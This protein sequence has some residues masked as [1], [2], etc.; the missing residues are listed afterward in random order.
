MIE[1]LKEDVWML[2]IAW[3][4]CVNGVI[5][6]RSYSGPQNTDTSRSVSARL[7]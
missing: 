4:V 5:L 6:V 3:K 7:M 2:Y 1:T